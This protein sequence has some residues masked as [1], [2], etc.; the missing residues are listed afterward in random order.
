MYIAVLD[1]VPDHMVPV[2]V[3]HATLGAHLEFTRQ[4]HWNDY[5]SNWLN[6]SFRKVVIKVNQGEFERI[7]TLPCVYLGHEK[8]VLGGANSCAVVCPRETTPNVL[9]FAKMWKPDTSTVER[10][11]ARIANLEKMVSDYMW[12]ESPGQGAW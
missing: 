12:Q 8:T 3:A 7:R 6:N 4:E 2:L 11:A 1:Q 10:Q 5:Y 9:T